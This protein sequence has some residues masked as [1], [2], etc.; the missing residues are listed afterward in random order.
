V[1]K[2][3]DGVPTQ[4][5]SS[6]TCVDELVAMAKNM[7]KAEVRSLVAASSGVDKD[8]V[9]SGVVNDVTGDVI[10]PHAIWNIS[11]NRLSSI[12]SDDYSLVQHQDV[13]KLVGKG[14]KAIDTEVYGTLKNI[15]D[16]MVI[17]VFFPKLHLKD[18]AKGID[19]GGKIINSYNKSRAFKGHMMANRK[20]CTNGMYLRKLIP[21]V[22][23]FE[24]HVGD[25]AEKIPEMVQDF[26][27]RLKEA[28]GK[29]NDIIKVA[30]ETTIEFDTIEQ[31]EPT[32]AGIL[33]S[34]MHAKRIVDEY[35]KADDQLNPTVWE[36][37]N[38][39]TNYI[40]HSG[41][42]ESRVDDLSNKAEK[43]LDSE[44]PIEILDPKEDQESS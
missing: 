18:D 28:T 15:E 19:V 16:V 32:I 22:E 33:S 24:I 41:I 35:Y 1:A 20:V 3:R 38:S 43:L 17:E 39:I 26:F 44:Y 5:I 31:I 8:K 7:D 37:Y 36:L 6:F 2:V 11:R 23:F 40:S 29:V 42:V 25:L 27:S 13:V 12:V 4:V 9:S 14:L 10:S 21:D 34:P 30:M